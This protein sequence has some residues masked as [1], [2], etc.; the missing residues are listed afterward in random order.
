MF[1]DFAWIGATQLKI[2]F[3]VPQEKCRGMD[4]T[5]VTFIR[6]L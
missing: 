6:Q 1:N 3:G 4:A 2:L 5:A